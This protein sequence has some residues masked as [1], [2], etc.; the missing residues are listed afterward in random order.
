MVSER[1]IECNLSGSEIVN[2]LRQGH[3]VRRSCWIDDFYIRI[4]N[5]AGF[6]TNGNAIIEKGTAVFTIATNGFFMHFCSSSQPFKLPHFPRDGE[7][8]EMAFADDWEDHGFIAREAFEE[9]TASLKE[10]I[11]KLER[12]SLYYGEEI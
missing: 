10:K 5:E 4:C 1:R 7:G 6:D 11:R 8:M 2:R 12:E 9:L 3:M